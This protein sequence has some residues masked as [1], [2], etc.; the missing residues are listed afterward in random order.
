MTLTRAMSETKTGTSSRLVLV[1]LLAAAFVGITVADA[2]ADSIKKPDDATPAV[3]N[4][5]ADSIKKPDDATPAVADA[6]ADSIKKPDDGMPAVADAAADSIKKPDDGMPAVAA[7][8]SSPSS[9]FA[10][11]AKVQLGVGALLVMYACWASCPCASC[12]CLHGLLCGRFWTH[13][14]DGFSS[15]KRCRA[16]SRIKI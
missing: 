15:A 14:T 6:A 11:A 12:W 16:T 5:A 8:S 7:T 1:V 10:G 9:S 4:A 3:A 2:A 13:P